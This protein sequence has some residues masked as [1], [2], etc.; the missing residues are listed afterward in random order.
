[1]MENVIDRELPV[2]AYYQIEM[3]LKERI[4]R[5][6]WK[7]AEQIPSEAKLAEYYA[8][9][10]ITLRQALAELEKDGVIR[11]QRGKGAFICENPVPFIHNL[12]YALVSADK[13]GNKPYNITAE[14]ITMRIFDVPNEEIREQLQLTEQDSVL[15]FKRIFYL[16]GTPMAIGRSW[17]KASLVPNLV[18]EGLINN[19]LSTTLKERYGIM[20]D[21][22]NDCLEVVRP[23]QGECHLLGISYDC[24]LMLVRGVSYTVDDVPV[25]Y[26]NTL[27]LGD[28]VRFN[29][30]LFSTK[31]GFEITSL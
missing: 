11:K 26:S 16:D 21:R 4:A 2:P 25:E 8:V 13:L 18:N 29:L 19:Q 9:S 3:D 6:E 30:Q 15:Y 12:N 14:V 17:L 23:T 5:G 7:V 31:N 27:W 1:M 28:R 20:V 24:P 22:I 10:R